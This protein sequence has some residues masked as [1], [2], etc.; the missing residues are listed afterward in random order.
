[1]K[2]FKFM[3][4]G[5]VIVAILPGIYISCGGDGGGS[6]ET[7]IAEPAVLTEETVDKTVQMIDDVVPFCSM[8]P[9]PASMT[10][11]LYALVAIA[12]DISDQTVLINISKDKAGAA[13]ETM[14]EEETLIEGDC[15][16]EII[17]R[18]DQGETTI[19]G[20]ILINNYCANLDD[21]TQIKANGA[22]ELSGSTQTLSNGDQKIRL[23]LNTP[24]PITI[25]LGEDDLSISITEAVLSM[26]QGT[27]AASLS[28]T[29]SEAVLAHGTDSYTLGNVSIAVSMTDDDVQ[30]KLT[31]TVDSMELE[32]NTSQGSVTHQLRNVNISLTSGATQSTMS[33][34]GTYSNSQ[35]GSVTIATP[36]PITV[37]DAGEIVSGKIVASGAQGT[38]VSIEASGGNLFE[39]EADTNG[40]GVYDYQP[41][42]MDCSA[43]DADSL[44]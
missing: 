21:E 14:A 37:N 8:G 20:N 4:V 35:E 28:L 22:A 42:T 6:S 3:L 33:I 30:E 29:L 34:S 38:K 40:D 39:I 13:A 26:T 2:K 36:V 17:M 19:S 23:E 5:L 1:M 18:V 44:L 10:A 11:S 41:G 43:F 9:S 12:Q 25:Q 16:G 7:P 27:D 32:E 15:G 24:T 31:I